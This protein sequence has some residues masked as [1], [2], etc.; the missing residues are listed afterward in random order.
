MQSH[1]LHFFKIPYLLY[2]RPNISTNIDDI[3][4]IDDVSP[5]TLQSQYW[6]VL[7]ILVV[8]MTS[9]KC[10]P[11]QTTLCKCGINTPASFQIFVSGEKVLATL[12]IS[13]DVEWHRVETKIFVSAFSRKF[14]ENLFTLFA[15]FTYENWICKTDYFHVV[16]TPAERQIHAALPH[17]SR[18]YVIIKQEKILMLS[19]QSQMITSNEKK[20]VIVHSDD[21]INVMIQKMII[22]NEKG[23]YCHLPR[24]YYLFYSIGRW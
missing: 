1:G 7:K 8:Y 23:V 12:Y 14:C 4:S 5:V 17:S 11:F 18:P 10:S 21:K 19:S 2:D 24:W 20:H 3:A 16:R 15:K 9:W 6:F 22:L 13:A